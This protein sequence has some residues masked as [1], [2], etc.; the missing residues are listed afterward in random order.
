MNWQTLFD[1]RNGK[2]YWKNSTGRVKSSDEAGSYDI[3]SGYIYVQVNRKHIKAATIIW[4]MHNGKLPKGFIVD[5]IDHIRNNDYLSNLRAIPNP[6]NSKNRSIASNNKS[7]ITGVSY[8]AGRWRAR[9]KVKG[10][11]L[12]L[13]RFNTKEE[14]ESARNQANIQYGFHTNHGSK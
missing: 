11:L 7:G 6:E 12:C 14:A 13:G 8:E 10:K 2:L 5:H 1:Y 3:C 9:I 4:E